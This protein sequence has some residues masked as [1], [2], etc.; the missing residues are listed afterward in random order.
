MDSAANA[1]A[2][3]GLI[4]N[5]QG[6][7]GTGRNLL[8]EAVSVFRQSGDHWKTA[9]ALHNLGLSVRKLEGGDAALPLFAESASLWFEVGYDTGTI[10]NLSSLAS[11][12][13]EQQNYRTS[14]VL[15]AAHASMANAIRLPVTELESTRNGS[16]LEN[17]KR[18]LEAEEFER[19]WREGSAMS[20]R[21]A[22]EM[23]LSSYAAA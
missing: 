15:L 16:V 6:N 10:Y 7:Y 21:E 12:A 1:L 3:L 18:C 9:S 17:A 2:N 4:E 20:G 8:E 23:A 13:V 5:D 11:L 19:A 22:V 14:V